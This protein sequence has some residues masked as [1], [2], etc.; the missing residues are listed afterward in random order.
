M[1]DLISTLSD[2]LLA[3]INSK[4]QSP[5]KA[6]IEGVIRAPLTM[7]VDE[8][9][10]R[11]HPL[12]FV[13]PDGPPLEVKWSQPHDPTNWNPACTDLSEDS[14][15]LAIAAIQSHQALRDAMNRARKP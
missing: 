15:E 3:L 6:E 7:L 13:G 1:T 10:L 14:L 5:S 4:P 9:H 2:Q 12:F 8:H 11:S